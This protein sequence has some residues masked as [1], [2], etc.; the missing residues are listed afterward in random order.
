V[1]AVGADRNLARLDGTMVG[2]IFPDLT[3]GE[4]DL[5]TASAVNENLSR[6]FIG[7]QKG[8]SFDVKGSLARE[9]LQSP[10]NP[11]GKNNAEVLAPWINGLDIVRR[12][13]DLWII[14]FTGLTE[15]EAALFEAPFQYVL[16]HVRPYRESKAHASSRTTWW[17]HQR[18]RHAFR[19][20]MRPYRR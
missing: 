14:D 6:A 10:V 18:P 4:V 8:G 13:R 1:A 15:R 9:W 19:E 2:A 3:A 20:A 7:N 11:N 17:L 5:T 16:N 12:P